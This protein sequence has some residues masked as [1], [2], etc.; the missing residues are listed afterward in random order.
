MEL[1]LEADPAYCLASRGG[2]MIC[3]GMVAG[4]NME[5]SVAYR[6]FQRS[7]PDWPRVKGV[8]YTAARPTRK[9]RLAAA[10]PGLRESPPKI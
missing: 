9:W 2:Q 6:P 7:H 5:K 4:W 3:G 8:R 1:A 10:Q